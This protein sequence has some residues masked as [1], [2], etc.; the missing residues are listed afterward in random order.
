[1]YINTRSHREL[2]ALLD[3]WA[4]ELLDDDDALIV[5]LSLRSRSDADKNRVE[6]RYPDYER[7]KEEEKLV[8][9]SCL[10]TGSRIG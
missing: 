3:R 8:Y 4:S 1:M 5:Q 9:P 10:Q 2:Q 7:L 6:I